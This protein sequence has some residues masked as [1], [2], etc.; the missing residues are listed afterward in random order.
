MT[1]KHVSNKGKVWI[2]KVCEDYFIRALFLY[3]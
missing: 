2:M 3:A 1:L